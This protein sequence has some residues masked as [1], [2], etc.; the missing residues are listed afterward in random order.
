MDQKLL[1]KFSPKSLILLL[2]SLLNEL[3]AQDTSFTLIE[4]F[5]SGKQADP[6]RET[7]RVTCLRN[8][9]WYPTTNNVKICHNDERG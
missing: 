9:N 5:Q 3:S 8:S 4:N 1:I 2:N 6:E 7:S